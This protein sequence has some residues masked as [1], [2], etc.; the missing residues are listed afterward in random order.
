[1]AELVASTGARFPIAPEALV[2]RHTED[3]SVAAPDVDLLR[4]GR[5]EARRPAC[6]EDDGC[7]HAMLFVAVASA[8]PHSTRAR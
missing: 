7:D 6:R 2:G 4:L 1:M 3:P 8:R 5:A